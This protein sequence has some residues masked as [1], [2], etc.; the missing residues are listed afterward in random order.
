ML[1]AGGVVGAD[2]FAEH[3]LPSEKAFFAKIN[4]TG[5]ILYLSQLRRCLLIF[6]PAILLRSV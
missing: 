2:Y 3:I 6:L 5:L 4:E 1:P